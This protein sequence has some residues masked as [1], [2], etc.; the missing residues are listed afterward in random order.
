MEKTSKYQYPHGDFISGF[1]AVSSYEL[2]CQTMVIAGTEWFD[3]HP[4]AEPKFHG[5]KGIYGIISEDNPVAKELVK[6]MVDA[7]DEE[8]ARS[9]VTGAMVQATISHVLW[10]H[11]HS[12]DDYI[13]ELTKPK[14]G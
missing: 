6:V 14:V 11:T 7:A 2:A 10:I 8:N 9:G 1:G 12:W 3:K 13:A 4:L 5:Y